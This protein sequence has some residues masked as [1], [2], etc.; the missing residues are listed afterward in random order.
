[1]IAWAFSS[2]LISPCCVLRISWTFTNLLTVL[3]VLVYV[4]GC[5][6]RG[7]CLTSVKVLERSISLNLIPQSALYKRA[8]PF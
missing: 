4:L 3:C 5:A 8:V 7:E 6:A 2:S 1:M